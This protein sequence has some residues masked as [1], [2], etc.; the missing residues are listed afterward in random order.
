MQYIQYIF[1]LFQIA[2]I[3]NTDVSW[4]VVQKELFYV[5]DALESATCV[6]DNHLVYPN[7]K[8]ADEKGKFCDIENIHLII[9]QYQANLN[10]Y[11]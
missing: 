3:E 2:E 9:S 11:T 4:K 5:I 1:Q 10:Y 7:D 6:L 8:Q